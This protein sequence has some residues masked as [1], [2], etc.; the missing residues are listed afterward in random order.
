MATYQ[1]SSQTTVPQLA[2]SVIGQTFQRLSFNSNIP[3]TT[4]LYYG[5]NNN[6][7]LLKYDITL[8]YADDNSLSYTTNYDDH[9]SKVITITNTNSNLRNNA[10]NFFTNSTN[11]PPTN[12]TYSLSQDIRPVTFAPRYPIILYY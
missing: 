1:I 5:A 6:N 3:Q 12:S 2:D 4:D 8:L 10:Y 9:Y 11:P 7:S